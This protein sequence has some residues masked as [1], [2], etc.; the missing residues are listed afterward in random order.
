M[1][2][3]PPEYIWLAQAFRDHLDSY[4]DPSNRPTRSDDPRKFED[5]GRVYEPIYDNA[6]THILSAL[7]DG[8]LTA[9]VLQYDGRPFVVPKEYWDDDFADATLAEGEFCGIGKSK[10]LK[11]RPI[12]LHTEDWKNWTAERAEPQNHRADDP[13]E[14]MKETETAGKIRLE[15]ARPDQQ[16]KKA[17]KPRGRGG[18]KPG[19]GAYTNQDR[20]LWK[21]MKAALDQGAAKSIWE[22]AGQFANKAPGDGTEDSKRRRLTK[23]YSDWIS[24]Q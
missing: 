14:S 5:S 17:A 2:F 11:D 8:T 3:L 12:V 20:V 18:R 16:R 4:L 19:S 21:K 13:N 10:N 7:R 1:Y 22:A 23:G 6:Q 24:T 9:F 15:D